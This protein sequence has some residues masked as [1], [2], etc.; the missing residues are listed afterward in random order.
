MNRLDDFLLDEKCVGECGSVLQ[1][2]SGIHVP[3]G[4]SFGVADGVGGW[5]DSG[6]DPSLFSQALMYHAHR[7]T[8]NAWAG[9]PEIDPTL[10]YAEREEVEGW[11]LT[12]YECLDLSFGGV[13]RERLV[14]AGRLLFTLSPRDSFPSGSSTAVI[15]SLNASSGLLRTAKCVQPPMLTL[16]ILY[17]ATAL[18]TV[19]SLS[20]DLLQSSTSR[21]P[22]H[23][24]S[25]VPC[26]YTS[27]RHVHTAH[28]LGS[29]LTKLPAKDVR[30]FSRACIDSP[31]AAA[32]F[33][34]TLRHGD[35][36]IAYVS[37]L[38]PA[39]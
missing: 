2:I 15:L 8:R 28:L 32:K 27:Q 18:E 13:C 4:V 1:L 25:I 11:E 10:D 34:T 31:S 35:I 24:S 5:V 22:R 6:I 30:R 16:L 26:M 23:I 39:L 29:Q 7:Y 3:K 9:E 33:E 36:I 17:V 21:L 12:P 20:S 14:Q 19:V 37:S 38:F